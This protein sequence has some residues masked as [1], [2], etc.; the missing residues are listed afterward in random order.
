MSS[1]P[2]AVG[3][4]S[5]YVLCMNLRSKVIADHVVL[6]FS[7][8]IPQQGPR[9]PGCMLDTKEPPHGVPCSVGLLV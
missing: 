4:L 7:G 8:E 5:F 9:R 3:L 6:V 1:H 2:E